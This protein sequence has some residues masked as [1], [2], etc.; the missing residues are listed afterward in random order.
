MRLVKKTVNFDNHHVY[1]FYYGDQLGTPGTVFTTFPY[2]NQ[3]KVPQGSEGTGMVIA[4]ALSV[5]LA[6]LRFWDARLR[7]NGVLPLHG[8]RF[9]QPFLWFRDPSGLQIELIGDDSDRRKPWHCPDAPDIGV[10]EGIRGI[11]HVTLS[12]APGNP[13]PIR[14][15]DNTARCF[16]IFSRPAPPPTLHHHFQVH[17]FNQIFSCTTMK[18]LF[19]IALTLVSQSL[20]AQKPG[21]ALLNPTNHALVLIDHQSQ[22]AFATKSITAEELRS[23]VGLVSGAASIFKVPTVVTTVARKT[24]SGPVFPE[25]T[26]F[27]PKE[28]EYVDRTTMNTWEDANAHKAITGKGKKKIVFAG[29]WTEVCIVGPALSAI[30]EGYE[31]YVITDACGG[32]STEAHQMAVQRMIQAGA[33]PMTSLQYL[34]ELQ[35]DWARGETYAAV[36]DLAKRFGGAY[37]LGIQY[38]KDMF[39]AEEG[40]K[41]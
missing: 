11:H 38:A 37:G 13:I 8:E 15:F 30:A 18:N 5:P 35:R 25:I 39:N 28:N 14:D 31:V 21:P 16:A 7:Q 34:L 9:G 29:L 20:F 41:K 3:P 12:I 1:H 6:S 19:F 17:F 32:V 2:K 22:M 36:N 24:F 23:N 4:T 33:Q 26:E 27:F 40:K 10:A